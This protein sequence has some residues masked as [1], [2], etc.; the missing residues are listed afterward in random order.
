M[1]CLCLGRIC[2][3]KACRAHTLPAPGRVQPLRYTNGPPRDSCPGPQ[4]LSPAL[5][6]P[7][8]APAV[9]P[10]STTCAPPERPCSRLSPRRAPWPSEAALLHCPAS[11]LS[12]STL[13]LSPD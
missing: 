8:A 5:T 3:D 13:L 12:G 6:V 2:L 7:L 9:L 11:R 10:W 4:T 1:P